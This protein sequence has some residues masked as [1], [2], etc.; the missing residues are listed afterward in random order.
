M[1]RYHA[2]EVAGLRARLCGA[3]VVLGSA[4]PSVES[5]TRALQGEYGLLRLTRRAA[6]NSRLPQVETVDLRE[7]LKAGNKTMFSRR[8]TELMEDRL[9]RGEQMMLFM[10]RRGYSSFVSCR[11]CGEAVKCPHCDV[12]LSVHRGGRMVCHYC[13]YEEKAVTACPVC[14]SVHIGGFRAGTQQIEEMAAREFPG[15]RISAWMRIP[16]EQG[17]ARKDPGGICRRR[18]RYSCGNTDDRKRP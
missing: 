5:F 17:W 15:A 1:P 6:E 10:N 16:Q 8:L 3:D 7:E 9:G 2:R 13:G 11:S 4:T 12:S 14:G 18:S